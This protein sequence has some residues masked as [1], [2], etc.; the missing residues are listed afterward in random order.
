MTLAPLTGVLLGK[1]LPSVHGHFHLRGTLEAAGRA[2]VVG[3]QPALQ[4][5][6]SGF[7]FRVRPGRTCGDKDGALCLR[8]PGGRVTTAT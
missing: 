3:T 6:W 7:R 1:V 8:P 4:H 2:A 5:G